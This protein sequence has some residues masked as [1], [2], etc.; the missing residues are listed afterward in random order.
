MVLVYDAPQSIACDP[1][2]FSAQ[3]YKLNTPEIKRVTADT[4]RQAASSV[5]VKPGG[6]VLVVPQEFITRFN[7]PA[8][9]PLEEVT[10]DGLKRVAEDAAA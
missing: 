7:R 5:A 9:A 1:T 6:H 3:T 2:Q 4:P 10:L 8:L